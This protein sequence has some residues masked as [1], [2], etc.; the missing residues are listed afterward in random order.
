MPGWNDACSWNEVSCEGWYP[1]GAPAAA[2]AGST[3]A[4]GLPPYRRKARVAHSAIW[5]SW[6]DWKQTRNTM[7]WNHIF[8]K[9]ISPLIWSVISGYFL[10]YSYLRASQDK[11]DSWGFYWAKKPEESFDVV[12]FRSALLYHHL[13]EVVS[14]PEFWNDMGALEKN[15][16][17]LQ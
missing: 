10:A 17:S 2:A 9:F 3:V 12:V 4:V 8:W 1:G 16:Q 5:A 14:W 7:L 13:T 6:I 11:A 15:R